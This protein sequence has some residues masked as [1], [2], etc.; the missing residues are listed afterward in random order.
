MAEMKNTEAVEQ[1]KAISE[2][3]MLLLSAGHEQ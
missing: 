1:Q 2:V 3:E